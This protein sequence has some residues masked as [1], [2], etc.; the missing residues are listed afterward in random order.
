MKVQWY[1]AWVQT[2]AL[3]QRTETM[4]VP[5]ELDKIHAY[6]DMVCVRKV[7]QYMITNCLQF[8]MP[9]WVARLPTQVGYPAGGSLTADEWK[10][11]SMV[12]CPVIV[13]SLFSDYVM[14]VIVFDRC[15]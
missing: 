9:G 11:M 14:S 2:K 1:E 6:L 10:A 4:R 5:R 12:Y 15:L 3:W 7:S 8:E 13:S